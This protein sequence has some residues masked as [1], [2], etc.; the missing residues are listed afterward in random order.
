MQHFLSRLHPPFRCPTHKFMKTTTH[1]MT[2]QLLSGRM[3]FIHVAV[4]CTSQGRK[5]AASA[6][7]EAHDTQ[8]LTCSRPDSQ[9]LAQV[10]VRKKE[11]KRRKASRRR[12]RA[13]RYGFWRAGFRYPPPGRAGPILCRRR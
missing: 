2:L 13:W 6:K 1:L 9:I 8:I 12:M 11:I 3:L 4:A 10:K 7:R 5:G